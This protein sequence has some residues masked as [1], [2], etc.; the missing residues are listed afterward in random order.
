MQRKIIHLEG[1]VAGIGRKCFA[2]RQLFV[3]DCEV[4]NPIL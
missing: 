4:G 3:M 2:L 1:D